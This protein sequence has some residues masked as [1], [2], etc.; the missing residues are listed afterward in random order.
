MGRLK[1]LHLAMMLGLSNPA[2]S[3]NY[4]DV[5]RELCGPAN[6]IH[7]YL[8][9]AGFFEVAHLAL[10]APN[11]IYLTYLPK[12][13]RVRALEAAKDKYFFGVEVVQVLHTDWTP[14]N[15]QNWRCIAGIRYIGP[16]GRRVL[17][18]YFNEVNVPGV[19]AAD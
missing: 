17:A 14:E 12:P 13:Q 9:Q 8:E 1:S 5:Q 11:G 6:A 3:A 18:A 10:M 15:Q 4:P 19:E 7:T 16:E 2:S